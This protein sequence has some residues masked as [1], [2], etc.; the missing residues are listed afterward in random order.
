[1]EELKF[2]YRKNLEL[3]EDICS[4]VF[5]H[6]ERCQVI[7]DVVKMDYYEWKDKVGIPFFNLYTEHMYL[8]DS[9]GYTHAMSPILQRADMLY[10]IVLRNQEL[11]A[12]IFNGDKDR[13]NEREKQ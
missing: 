7:N 2:R 1:M 10:Q 3:L 8:G 13:G 12:V 5:I 9:L 4:Y 11:E 6:L